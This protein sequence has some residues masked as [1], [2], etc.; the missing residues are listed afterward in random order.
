[1]TASK[2]ITDGLEEEMYAQ[3][4]RP[5]PYLEG[6][7]HAAPK[8]VR[9]VS[10]LHSVRESST[11]LG[12]SNTEAKEYLV[13]KYYPENVNFCVVYFHTGEEKKG[14]IRWGADGPEVLKGGL[15]MVGLT[16]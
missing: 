10:D 11:V 14:K 1:M 3:S 13:S 5:V 9:C 7:G 6:E 8:I 4:L 12:T 16:L 2:C 15:S